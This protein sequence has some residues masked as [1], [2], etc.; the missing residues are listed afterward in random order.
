M[1]LDADSLKQGGK[2]IGAASGIGV[3]AYNFFSSFPPPLFPAISLL[4][5]AISGAILFIVSTWKPPANGGK[6]T[7][8]WVVK[9][10]ATLIV[11]SIPLLIAY[12]LLFQFTTIK[13]RPPFSQ[14]ERIQIGFGKAEW[15]LTEAGRKW[16]R[17]Q[18]T[19]TVY[20]MVENEAAFE[21]RRVEKLWQ[22]WSIY[23]AGLTLI[24]LFF[25]GFLSWTAGFALLA[26]HKRRA[27]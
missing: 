4:T 27:G 9:R 15:S 11:I 16:T 5:A 6:R 22:T 24:V 20:Q 23:C 18:P 7:V 25:L 26:N 12:I 10:G 8:P 1:K 17:D 13:L 21:Q 2:W 19:I 3:P 14:T